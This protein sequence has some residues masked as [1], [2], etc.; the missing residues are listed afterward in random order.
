ML[1]HRQNSHASSGRKHTSRR[2]AGSRERVHSFKNLP[3]FGM[4]YNALLPL[5]LE[6]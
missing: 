1:S 5:E 2:E 4:I 3:V 6:R